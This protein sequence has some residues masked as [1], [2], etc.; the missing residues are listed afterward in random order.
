MK[1]LLIASFCACSL[2]GCHLLGYYKYEKAVR[3]PSQEAATVQYP[4]SFE[5]GI[6]IKGPMLMAV[7]V[8][9]NDFFPPGNTISASET[10][11]RVAEC[12]SR[13]ETYDTSVLKVSENLYFVRFIPFVSR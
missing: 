2:S 3:A 5:D 7:A 11:K 9:M 12:L 1:M 13:K 8:A 4:G 10:N 6:H